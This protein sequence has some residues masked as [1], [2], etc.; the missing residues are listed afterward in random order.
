MAADKRFPSRQSAGRRSGPNQD[1]IDLKF[2]RQNF[3]QSFRHRKRGLSECDGDYLAKIAKI[4]RSASRMD[5]RARTAKFSRK[6]C[7]D[8]NRR[9]RFQKNALRCL[10]HDFLPA[11]SRRGKF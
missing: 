10:F 11:L 6:N 8:L 4:D 1:S 5:N 2:R 7:W 3:A 9:Q